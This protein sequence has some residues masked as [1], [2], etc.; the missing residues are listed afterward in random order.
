MSKIFK[1]ITTWVSIIAVVG[2]CVAAAVIIVD[3]PAQANN[4]IDGQNGLS[5]Y[6]IAV[7]NGFNG[8]E[9]EWLASLRGQD[10]INGVN[11]TNGADGQNGL[12]GTN[13]QNGLSAYDIAVSN[14]FVGSETEWLESLRGQDGINGVKGDKGDKGDTGATGVAVFPNLT[15]HVYT[16]VTEFH[17]QLKELAKLGLGYYIKVTKTI[18]VTL[19]NGVSMSATIQASGITVSAVTSYSLYNNAYYYLSA[20]DG[21]YYTFT[22]FCTNGDEAFIKV[23]GSSVVAGYKQLSHYSSTSLIMYIKYVRGTF[24]DVSGLELWY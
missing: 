16:T 8:T 10:G 19:D 21:A 6:D 17:S 11:G 13:G 24:T 22:N 20:F 14:G 18:P 23:T 5:A 3:K 12:N 15:A 4:G 2:A 1:Q 9:R 7:A